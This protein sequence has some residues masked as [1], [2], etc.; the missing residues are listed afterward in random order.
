MVEESRYRDVQASRLSDDSRN[1]P[2]QDTVNPVKPLLVAAAL[3]ATWNATRSTPLPLRPTATPA[4]QQRA[5]GVV[6]RFEVVSTVDAWGGAT[7]AGAAGPY[8]VVTG[9]VHGRL[10]PTHP[11]NAGIVD[12]AN[13]PR[14]ADGYVDYT[15][16]AV[17]LRPKTAATARRVLFYDVANRGAKPALTAFIGASSLVKGVAPGENFPSM[18]RA[19]YTVVWSG[20]QSNV[21]QSGAGATGLLGV[22]FP[23]A[24]HGDG[25][26][27]TGLS[28]EEYIPETTETAYRFPLTYAPASLSDLSEVRFTARQ[29]WV[30][31]DGKQS[32]GAPSAPVVD[33]HYVANDNGTAFVEFTPPA[34]VP[35]ADGS[36]V[37]PGAGTIYSFTF[38]AR[39]PVVSGIGLAAVRDL[40]GFLKNAAA[41]ERGNQNPVADLKAAACAAGTDCPARPVG[42][43]DVAIGAGTSQSGRFLRDF[44]WQ[45]FNKDGHGAKVFDGLLPMIAGGRRSWVNERFAQPWRVS[46][47][48]E[49]HW[50]PGDQFPFAYGVAT[51]PVGGR[52]DGLLRSCLASATCPKIMQVD[53]S[54]EWWNGRASLVVTDGAGHDAVLPDNVRY[55]LVAGTQHGDGGGVGT[56]VAYQP[57]S[58]AR[59]LLA[60]SAVSETPVERALVPALEAWIVKGRRPP[61]SRYPT[62]AG[63]GLAAPDRASVGFPDLSGAAV[64]Y[65]ANATPAALDLTRFGAVNQLFV[66][67]YSGAAPVADL[68]R[69]YKL[70]VPKVDANGNE[71]GGIRMPEVAAPVATYTGWNVRAA[72]RSAGE[73][74]A[75]SGAAIPFAVAPA[76]RA[77][78]DP[79]STLA[80]L[81]TGRADY[82]ARFGTAADALA[83]RGYLLAQDVAT[84][85]AAAATISPALIPAP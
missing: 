25:S 52:T 40:V 12:L 46:R 85:K 80:Q 74:C 72:M 24:R 66:T 38:R 34:T 82:Q 37:A 4:V 55:Y 5:A 57:T 15:T 64:P 14:D 32:F 17:I 56:G 62:V 49:E 18:L 60:P 39:D 8:T 16:D 26:P 65:G 61:A 45:G 83:S 3:L 1:A 78:A 44:L 70:L 53:G 68:A 54:F 51:D 79:R 6:D 19:G 31:A 10:L 2:I 23:V 81:Y 42:N 7:P 36:A 35:A 22:H 43:F 47:Q 29:T 33:W 69:Q 71:T 30:G 28:R 50:M 11:D 13:A 20:W 75:M 48:H 73:S 27:I 63:G 59:C 77:P 84:A 76:A 41:D 67:D 58:T 21:A 9:I